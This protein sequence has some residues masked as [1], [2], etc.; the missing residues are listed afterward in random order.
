MAPQFD[1]VLIGIA[2]AVEM[3]V[4][5]RSL[6]RT[7]GQARQMKNG[8]ARFNRKISG[9][10]LR[11]RL[12]LD[13]QPRAAEGYSARLKQRKDILSQIF[14]LQSRPDIQR[15]KTQIDGNRSRTQSADTLYFQNS[16][17]ALQ[18]EC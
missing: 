4:I 16:I 18:M 6:Q 11:T 3:F 10:F 1:F 15:E 9:K 2:P 17:A 5:D 13:P 7:T 14:P 8:L 12:S